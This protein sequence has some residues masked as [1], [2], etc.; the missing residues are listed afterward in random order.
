MN[1]SETLSIISKLISFKSITP[2]GLDCLEYVSSFLKELNFSVEIIQYGPVYNMFAK[3]K[4]SDG[5]HV[6]FG[7][8][9]DV[10]PPGN[11]W[12][13]NPYELT[14]QNSNGKEMISGLGI[15]DMKGAIG[16]FLSALKDCINNIK[17]TVSVLLTTDEEGDAVD[18]IRKVI[19]NHKLSNEKFDLFVLGEP[20]CY[21]IAGDAIKIGRRGSVTGIISLKGKKGHIAYPEFTNSSINPLKDILDILHNK[22][23]GERNEYFEASRVQVTGISNENQTENVIPGDLQICFGA[24]F[25]SNYTGEKIIEKLSEK[26]NKAC[27]KYDIK[28][29]IAWKK[30]G[31]SFVV[32]DKNIIQW[33]RDSVKNI[34]GKE[35]DFNANGATS[36][37]R[38]LT[39]LGPVVEIG[40]NEDQA[41]QTNECT[42]LSN[43]KILQN[44]Y[45][46]LLK[47][48]TNMPSSKSSN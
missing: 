18:G 24:R 15:V 46:E 34:S 19:E 1:N 38:F 44:I 31:E 41:H 28:Y 25:N 8:H 22:T 5:P 12:N 29:S 6:C 43:I 47:N 10:V 14:Q 35:I 32:H 7:G 45:C 9:V 33:I 30:H 20:S 3:L 36:D 13:H 40:L 2:L 4:K 11:E 26:I 16:C 48:M 17:G 21:K 39:K 42:E 37:G 27:N 23:I